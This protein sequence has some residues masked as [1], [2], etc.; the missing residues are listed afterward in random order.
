MS[1]LAFCENQFYEKCIICHD[2]QIKI[3]MKRPCQYCKNVYFCSFCLHEYLHDYSSQ[4]CHCKRFIHELYKIRQI[5]SD[6]VMMILNI[7]I[8]YMTSS[9]NLSL[10]ANYL[11][12]STMLLRL[13]HVDVRLADYTNIFLNVFIFLVTDFTLKSRILELVYPLYLVIYVVEKL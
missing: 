5:Q 13:I 9:T 3:L 7:F 10:I 2:S 12:C 1:V 4:C 8:F 6:Y 11:L